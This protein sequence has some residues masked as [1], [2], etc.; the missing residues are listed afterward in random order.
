[1]AAG[2]LMTGIATEAGIITMM[3]IAGE[4]RPMLSKDPRASGSV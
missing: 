4:S 1:M 2:M 3:M